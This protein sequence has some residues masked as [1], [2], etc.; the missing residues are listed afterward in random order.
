MNVKVRQLDN[1]SWQIS[2]EGIEVKTF[3]FLNEAF[4]HIKTEFLE[5]LEYAFAGSVV[6]MKVDVRVVVPEFLSLQD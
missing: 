6:T 3:V 1:G 4:D 2:G 5:D